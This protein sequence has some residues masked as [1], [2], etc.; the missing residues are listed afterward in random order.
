MKVTLT[1]WH[2]STRASSITYT[3][4]EDWIRS[5]LS[6]Q[7]NQMNMCVFSFCC[8]YLKLIEVVYYFILIYSM[9]FK[10]CIVKFAYF[11]IVDNA[12]SYKD[13]SFFLYT[14][15]YIFIYQVSWQT[16]AYNTL[17]MTKIENLVFVIIS[18]ICLLSNRSF[19]VEW[20]FTF[21]VL[22][23]LFF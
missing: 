10:H 13:I 15:I 23:F 14:I 4:V 3:F 17:V 1:H 19:C 9:L 18:M 22:Y 5:M 21:I 16:A 11:S 12:I 7:R 6:D 2:C 8:F 20:I